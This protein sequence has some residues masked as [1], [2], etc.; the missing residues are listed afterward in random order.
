MGRKPKSETGSL[1]TAN[2]AEIN[3][4]V[5]ETLFPVELLDKSIDERLW[6]FRTKK[7]AHR[8]LNDVTEQVLRAI[9][10]PMPAQVVC[11]Y[12]P[13]GVGKGNLA[14][15]VIDTVREMEMAA[16][17]SDRSYV[18]AT[19]HEIRGYPA[20]R[21]NWSG[22][23]ELMMRAVNEPP[24]VVEN[25]LHLN[26]RDEQGTASGTAGM[27]LTAAAQK[28]QYALENCLRLRKTKL[29]WV[30]EA[31]NLRNASMRNLLA[32]IDIFKSIANVTGT[33]I[34]L[35]GTYELLAFSE[36]NGHLARRTIDVHFP[37]YH[38][39]VA[40]DLG[41]FATALYSLQGNLPLRT[42]PN[43]VERIDYVFDH[44]LG[45]VGILKD[46]LYKALALAIKDGERRPFVTYLEATCMLDGRLVASLD[47]ILRGEQNW[48][49]LESQQP[50]LQ[51]RIKTK[52]A[53]PVLGDS[54][55]EPT[56]LIAIEKEARARRG[57][58]RPGTRNP[59]RDRVGGGDLYAS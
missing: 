49:N 57:R 42:T 50:E 24:K 58:N 59:I 20:G 21:F 30:D 40:A 52:P 3:L 18:P 45:C 17:L 19:F 7:V 36:P 44:C 51:S 11:I 16:M 10:Y 15:K 2:A 48:A 25:K 46:W 1:K 5:P 43:L 35:A 6:H 38:K 37:R 14:G 22:E 8:H 28:S 47:E 39:T 29:L 31:Q 32:Q 26:K 34:V 13:S 54:A 12:G 55:A 53:T 56:E 33:V 41:Q 4:L 9:M 23:F 27:I